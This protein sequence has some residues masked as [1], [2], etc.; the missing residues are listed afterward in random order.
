MIILIPNKMAPKM[1]W[2]CRGGSSTKMFLRSTSSSC[3]LL[4][5]NGFIEWIQLYDELFELMV[6]EETYKYV[7]LPTV[8]PHILP[9][10]FTGGVFWM[11]VAHENWDHGGT[12]LSGIAPIKVQGLW[13]GSSQLWI[14]IPRPSKYPSKC[15]K[16]PIFTM[17]TWRVLG[18]FVLSPKPWAI[19]RF[20]V[21][22]WCRVKW[23]RV[24][25]GCGTQLVQKDFA[26]DHHHNHHMLHVWY[27][28]QHLP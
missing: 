27:I 9:H 21:H 26:S 19:R 8:L 15:L 17:A 22:G 6:Y 10:A 23:L 24:G 25:K 20:P 1:T 4:M 11:R 16:G 5:L 12:F 13:S 3:W 2:L 14:C 18:T 7:S 28:C